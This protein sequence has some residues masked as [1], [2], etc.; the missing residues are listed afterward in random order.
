MRFPPGAGF[1]RIFPLSQS[2]PLAPELD[3]QPDAAAVELPGTQ[4]QE[5]AE[6]RSVSS[7]AAE[8]AEE[9]VPLEL[10]AQRG[11]GLLD[12]E[13]RREEAAGPRLAQDRLQGARGDSPGTLQ[14]S[15]LEDV[16]QLPYVSRPGQGPQPPER[17]RLDAG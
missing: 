7:Q 6:R 4:T 14:E 3:S 17:R 15:P 12:E 1:A 2:P 13:V 5:P 9:V 8:V 10:L 16:P 11:Q